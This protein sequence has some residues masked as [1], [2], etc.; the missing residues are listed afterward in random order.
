[1][2]KL[3][4]LL[5]ILLFITNIHAKECYQP[6][7]YS[8]KHQIKMFIDGKTSNQKANIEATLHVRYL[9]DNGSLYNIFWLEKGIIK[10]KEIDKND[11][12]APFLVKNGAK[13]DRFIIKEIKSLSKDVNIQKRL[14]GIIDLLQIQQKEG[15]YR[16]INSMGSVYVN[17]TVLNNVYTIKHLKQYEKNIPSKQIEYLH[18]HT[19]I[20]LDKSCSTWKSVETEHEIRI[21]IRMMKST[22]ND[23]R[24]FQLEK[25]SKALNK[26]HWFFQLSTDILKWGFNFKKPKAKI[27]LAN[28]LSSFDDKEKEM[29]SLLD[30]SEKFEKWVKDNINFLEHLSSMLESKSLNNSVSKRLFA[31]LGYINSVKATEILSQVTLNENI[32][33]TERFRG[34]M[35]LKNTSAPIDE[36]LMHK[37][38][39][40]G[41]NPD[42]GSD[43]IKNAVGMLI[44][45]L[46]RE[47]VD[48]VPEQYEKIIDSIIDTMQSQTDKRVSL[49]AAGNMLS[50]APD[51]VVDVIDDIL[52]TTG[53]AST[54]G[55]SAKALSRIEKSNLE[56]EVFQNLLE[57]ENNRETKTALIK[58]SASSKDFQSNTNYQTFLIDTAKDRSSAST[59][60]V[61]SLDVLKKTDFG[62][63]KEEKR[64]IRK[65]M[66]GEQDTYVL[67]RLRELYRR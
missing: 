9:E 25:S 41:F 56:V 20:I 18:S 11:I 46:A 21:S 23:D 32:N 59:N 35:G 48:R 44:G 6:Y 45:T 2:K 64:K 31:K 39:E 14:I 3:E 4:T 52:T 29:L 60:R 28:A 27:S 66:L 61:A 8:D 57:D 22:I 62:K 40:Q 49:A 1:M 12:Y 55:Q 13:D 65:M 63:S 30:D 26:N 33:E 38:I 43:F 54:R 5:F 42:N 67:K 7:S 53:E 37:I 51:S 36:E 10:K 24:K 58:A 17:Q 19:D 34:L 15:I 50:T 16:F 47:R